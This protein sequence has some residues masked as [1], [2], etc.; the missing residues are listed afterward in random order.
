[1]PYI[2]PEYRKKL[3]NELDYLIRDTHSYVRND[4]GKMKGVA[5][6]LVIRL[7][8]GLLKPSEGWSYSSLSDVIGTLE[9]AKLEM[10]RRLLAPYEDDAILKNG[11]LDEYSELGGGSDVNV[12]K[13]CT[14]CCG[15][16]K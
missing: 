3:D 6:Y 8:L 13:S 1:M 12:R 10:Y 15:P 2:D 7:A 4:P 5:H 16:D 14:C 9:A 11:D